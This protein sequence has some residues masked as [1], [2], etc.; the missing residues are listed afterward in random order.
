ML[1]AEL[2]TPAFHQGWSVTWKVVFASCHLRAGRG[3][4]TKRREDEESPVDVNT[5]PSIAPAQNW[6]KEGPTPG[7]K[8]K[9]SPGQTRTR[10][11]LTLMLMQTV[12]QQGTKGHLGF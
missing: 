6:V 3:F 5:P 12:L 8:T 4:W 7:I 2:D 9:T 11:L 10:C 1:A